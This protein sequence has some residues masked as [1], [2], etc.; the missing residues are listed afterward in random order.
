MK[1]IFV[2]KTYTTIDGTF[3]DIGTSSDHND[4][5]YER[6]PDLTTVT[7]MDNGTVIEWTDGYAHYQAENGIYYSVPMCFEFDLLES[8]NGTVQMHNGYNGTD[9]KTITFTIT[10]LGHYK[11]INQM[12]SQ[13]IYCNGELLKSYTLEQ[14]RFYFAF[15]SNSSSATDRR[16]KYANFVAYPI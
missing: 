14:S 11:I 15:L 8:V 13:Y 3:K 16:I 10:Q 12:D 5:W 7:R 1:C 2:S 9:S 6:R 4:Y